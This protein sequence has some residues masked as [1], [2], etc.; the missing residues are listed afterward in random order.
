MKKRPKGTVTSSHR[1]G[2]VQKEFTKPKKYDRPGDTK[3][4]K[5]KRHLKPRTF[6]LGKVKQNI[7]PTQKSKPERRRKKPDATGKQDR[8]SQ[9]W[10]T[11]NRKKYQKDKTGNHFAQS[12]WMFPNYQKRQKIMKHH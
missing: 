2:T 7:N 5:V 10:S 6:N 8:F 1:R 3:T 11:Q 12:K 9:T 4:T